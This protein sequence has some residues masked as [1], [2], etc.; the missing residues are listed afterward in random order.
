MGWSSLPDPLLTFRPATGRTRK[1]KGRAST[2]LL[3]GNDIV[4]V[5]AVRF[6]LKTPFDRNVVTHGDHMETVLDYAF[7]HLDIGG[8]QKQNEGEGVPYPVM[9]TEPV[10]NPNSS[11]ASENI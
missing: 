7:H 3:V 11:R 10:A 4:N 5:E 9:M 2:D 1:E 6:S 8:G